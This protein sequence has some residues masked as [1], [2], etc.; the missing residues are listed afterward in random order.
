MPERPGDPPPAARPQTESGRAELARLREIV[1]KAPPLP[2]ARPPFPSEPPWSACAAE[3][4][5]L[6]LRVRCD[7]GAAS[8]I[9]LRYLAAT[10]GWQAPLSA[11]IPRLRCRKCQ[12]RP[13][14]VELVEDATL[15][16]RIPQSG[17]TRRLRL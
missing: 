6:W 9:P 13:G 8:A 15:D 3:L 7:C 2:E 17:S 11:I 16:A 14:S 12:Q 10:R 1:R 5:H 4:A